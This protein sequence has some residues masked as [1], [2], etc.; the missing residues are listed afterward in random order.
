M[1][2]P[3]MGLEK[4]RVMKDSVNFNIFLSK[5]IEFIYTHMKNFGRL[6]HALKIWNLEKAA[7]TF[8]AFP[9]SYIHLNDEIV[10]IG[11]N[12]VLG[13]KVIVLDLNGTTVA[14]KVKYQGCAK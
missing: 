10:W 4:N 14:C 7:L 3:K 6:N 1:S 12:W 13:S 2:S 5:I 8:G 11:R 9:D